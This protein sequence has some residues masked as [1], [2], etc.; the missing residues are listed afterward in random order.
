MVSISLLL[1]TW[2]ST[3]KNNFILFQIFL[4]LSAF[5]KGA[6]NLQVH[7]WGEPRNC[8]E[9]AQMKP[10]S[11]FGHARIKKMMVLQYNCGPRWVTARNWRALKVL[12]DWPTDRSA[13]WIAFCLF[14][15]AACSNHRTKKRDGKIEKRDEASALFA[16][17]VLCVRKC[18]FA[19][20]LPPLSVHHL[21]WIYPAASIFTLA[22]DPDSGKG[23]SDIWKWYF[24]F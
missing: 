19:L 12:T 9:C 24:V 8:V 2:P 18:P 14:A 10:I 20:Y 22:P 11:V 23:Y 13:L 3:K 5:F 6:G 15:V 17:A 7:L 16:A 21:C 1:G 4:T